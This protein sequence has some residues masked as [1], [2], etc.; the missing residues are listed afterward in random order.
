MVNILLIS[1]CIELL[2]LIV[3]I[4]VMLTKIVKQCIILVTMKNMLAAVYELFGGIAPHSDILDIKE[5]FPESD[6]ESG[7]GLEELE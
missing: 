2:V 5:D 1:I 6:V 7:P 4:F 3:T